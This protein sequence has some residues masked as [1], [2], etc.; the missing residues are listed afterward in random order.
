MIKQHLKTV[1]TIKCKIN[2]R[3]YCLEAVRKQD[4]QKLVKVSIIGVPNAGKSTLIN[5]LMDQR[6]ISR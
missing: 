3:F 5:S 6:V 2:S 4:E 1:W